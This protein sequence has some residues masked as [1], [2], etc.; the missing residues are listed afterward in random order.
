MNYLI[1][2]L[3]AGEF[4]TRYHVSIRLRQPITAEIYDAIAALL[5]KHTR[6][7]FAWKG[8]LRFERQT[9]EQTRG[10]IHLAEPTL[11]RI[12]IPG[13]RTK[14]IFLDRLSKLLLQWQANPPAG[15]TPNAEPQDSRPLGPPPR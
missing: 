7:T 10:V 3:A 8:W 5:P 12:D 4:Q 13:T 2:T 11:I 1:Q 15:L 6:T 14:D 9:H